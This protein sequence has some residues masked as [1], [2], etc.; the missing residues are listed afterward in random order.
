MRLARQLVSSTDSRI[1]SS[2]YPFHGL[3]PHNNSSHLFWDQ[4]SESAL[5]S[6]CVPSDVMHSGNSATAR[7]LAIPRQGAACFLGQEAFPLTET[8]ELPS[9]AKCAAIG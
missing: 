4:D 1:L 6:V 3:W 9:L 8:L 2:R 5:G 7:G